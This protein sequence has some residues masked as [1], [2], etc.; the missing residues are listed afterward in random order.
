MKSLYQNQSRFTDRFLEKALKLDPS[1]LSDKEIVDLIRYYVLSIHKEADEVL[2]TCDWKLHVNSDNSI[3]RAKLYTE[4]I[5][6]QKFVWGLMHICG[7]TPAD[8]KKTY[9]NKTKIVEEKFRKFEEGL[10]NG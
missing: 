5:D 7:M 8:I 10:K 9:K 3:D 2:D 6:L 4:L 1:N